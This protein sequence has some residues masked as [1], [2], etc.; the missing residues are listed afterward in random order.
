MTRDKKYLNE[1]KS[2]SNSYV[3]FNDGAKGRNR[4]IGKLVSPGLPS[5]DDVLLI[6]GLTTNFISIRQLCEQGFNVHFNKSECIVSNQDQE[7]IR[8]T[9][10]KDKCYMWTPQNKRQGITCLSVKEGDTKM[11]HRMVQHLCMS[12]E[13][14]ST[15]ADK[16]KGTP[17]ICMPRDL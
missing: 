3:T 10:S 14:V 12:K 1:V 6:E 8:S 16:V 15:Q 13:Y 4:G 2:Y 9:K 5:L 11:S 17:R 7:V